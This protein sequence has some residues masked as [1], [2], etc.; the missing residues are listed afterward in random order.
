MGAHVSLGSLDCRSLLTTQHFAT[1]AHFLRATV[2]SGAS[3]HSGISNRMR[4][5]GSGNEC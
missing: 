4:A 5:T 2:N 3:G 1:T